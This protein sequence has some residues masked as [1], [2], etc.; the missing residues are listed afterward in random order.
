MELMEMMKNRRSVRQYTQERIPEETM[1]KVL[2]AGL[3]APSG[4]ARRPWEFILVR[5]RETEKDV[6]VP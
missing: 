4:R 2:Q 6:R 5:D 1:E 3:L